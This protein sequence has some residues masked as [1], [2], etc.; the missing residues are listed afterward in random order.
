MKFE[1]GSRSRKVYILVAVR[2]VRTARGVPDILANS[3]AHLTEKRRPDALIVFILPPKINSET[4]MV[5]LIITN[6]PTGR[7]RA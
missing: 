4:G 2:G 5:S 6:G 1:T 7:N 3:F